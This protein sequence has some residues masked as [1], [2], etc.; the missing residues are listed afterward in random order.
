[1][2]EGAKL[3]AFYMQDEAGKKRTSKQISSIAKITQLHVAGILPRTRLYNILDSSRNS[4]IT[5]II[6]PPGSGKTSL[7]SSYLS[8]RKIPCLWYSIDG[9]DKDIATFFHYMELALRKA[10]PN[11]KKPLPRYT[12]DYAGGVLV[13]AR[14]YFE[15]AFSR[16]K[17]PFM[18]VFDN[19][20]DVPTRSHFHTMITHVLS[21]VPEGIT[22]VI[23]SRKEPPPAF[24]RLHVHGMAH[25]IGWD[26]IRFTLEEARELFENKMPGRFPN[27]AFPALYE[28][29]DGW[30]AGLMISLTNIMKQSF[31]EEIL[32]MVSSQNI[33][34]YFAHEVFYKLDK[35]IQEFLL[36]TSFLP[37]MK[38]EMTDKLTRMKNA[39]KILNNLVKEC[40]FIKAYSQ[41]KLSDE[42]PAYKYHMLFREFLLSRAKSAFDPATL[43]L[44]KHDAA[45]LLEESGN[46]EDAVQLLHES[47]DVKSLIPIISKWAPSLIRQGRYETLHNYLEFIP[48]GILSDDPYMLYWSGVCR[49]PFHPGK[50][51]SYFEKAFHTFQ[52]RNE[53]AGSFLSWAGLVESII[54]GREGLRPL[55]HLALAVEQMMEQFQGFPSEDIEVEVAWSV[56]RILSLRKPQNFDTEKWLNR[57]QTITEETTDIDQKIRILTAQA[58]YL[59]SVGKFG[60]LETT[61]ETLRGMIQ[62]HEVRPL[63]ILTVSWL[64]A[65]FFNVMSMYEECRKAVSEGLELAQSLKI[66]VMEHMLLGHGVISSLKQGDLSHTKQYL[67]KMAS[68][69]SLMK[70]WEASFYHYCA[71]WGALYQN[72]LSQALTHAENCLRLCEDIGNPWTISIAHILKAYLAHAFGENKKALKHLSQARSIGIQSNNEFTPFICLLTE[73]YFYLKEGKEVPALEAIR[74]GMQIGREKGFMNLFMCEP[75]ALETIVTKALEHGIEETYVKTLIQRNAILPDNHHA[76]DELW[77]WPLKIYTLGRFGLIKDGNPVRFTGKVQQKPL[78]MLKALIAFGGR[79]VSEERLVDII[80]PDAEG[81]TVHSAFATTLSRLRQLLGT[82]HAVKFQDGKAALDQRYCYVDVW[83]FERILGKADTLWTTET[84]RDKMVK[85]KETQIEEAVKLTEKALRIYTG[86]FLAGDNEPWMVSIR[87]RLRN[88]ILRTVKRVGVYYEEAGEL[89]KAVECYQKGLEVDDLME[90]FYQRMMACYQKLGRKAEALSVYNR[91]CKIL[92]AQLSIK[93]S[94]ETEALV[95]EIKR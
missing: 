57:I 77:P 22:F 54:L 16:I 15:E 55:D 36:K 7:I 82:E 8:D 2:S 73:A 74:K 31:N 90:E 84:E 33:Y 49:L 64:R 44:I 53:A 5:F 75:G 14:R 42:R 23:L 61:L 89:G 39:D 28:K 30:A 24:A 88:K 76:V 71:A 83:A 43:S 59:Y 13:F 60:T 68:A 12:P 58:S 87:E 51:Q 93:P 85:K 78:S 1:M 86:P 26:T 79:E 67:Q 91:C 45:V 18:F 34:D 92:S 52:E 65:A 50:S 40:C 35:N 32:D 9:G 69:S 29:T 11:K 20:Q 38:I 47:G 17:I 48:G 72:N 10:L 37:M 4:P 94:P 70:P 19:Y 21:E 56:F 63:T 6:S 80:W 81:D 25:I 46:I 95:R 66:R 41:G 3:K 62:Q 27:K